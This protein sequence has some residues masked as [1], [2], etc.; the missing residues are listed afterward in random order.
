MKI[1]DKMAVAQA[2]PIE[3]IFTKLSDVAKALKG[4]QTNQN[5]MGALASLR[6]CVEELAHFVKNEQNKTS[7]Y[8]NTIR[9]HEDEIDHLKQKSLKGKIIISS[10]NQDLIKTDNQLKQENKTLAAHV[11]DLVKLK[12]K[13]M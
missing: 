11:K 12:Y 10:K 3:T 6:G 8:E 4:K 13:V 7:S 9:E 5:L 2:V 1:K